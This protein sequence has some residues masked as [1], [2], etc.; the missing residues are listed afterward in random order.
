MPLAILCYIHFGRIVRICIR[1]GI[2]RIEAHCFN[3][4][5]PRNIRH[6]VL[7]YNSILIIVVILLSATTLRFNSK[8]WSLIE[9]L[10]YFTGTI[11]TSGNDGDQIDTK[12]FEMNMGLSI[13]LE[14]FQIIG[15]GL[16][17]SLIQAGV[18]YQRAKHSRQRLDLTDHRK[19]VSSEG[20]AT[21][22]GAKS[23][24]GAIPMESVVI[25]V[26]NEEIQSNGYS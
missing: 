8:E 1:R 19:L 7:F 12:F 25:L 4:Q 9:C 13:L 21:A 2:R 16:V 11:S 3:R 17:S 15:L 5:E 23:N 26:K 22:N 14:I 24:V 20:R 18:G 6:K 10:Y